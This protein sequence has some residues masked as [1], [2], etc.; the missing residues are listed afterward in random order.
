ME[1]I[2]NQPIYSPTYKQPPYTLE[3]ASVAM[4]IRQINARGKNIEFEVVSPDE[5]WRGKTYGEWLAECW[6]KC[7]S[8]N[9]DDTSGGMLFLRASTAKGPLVMTG[10]NVATIS[11]DTSIFLP[12]ITAEMDQYDSPDLKTEA[13]WRAAANKDIDEGDP[14]SKIVATIDDEA[15]VNDLGGFRV[16]SPVFSLNVPNDSLLKDDLEVKEPVGTYEAVA[17]GYCLIIKSLPS[18]KEPYTIKIKAKGRGAY[19]Q[20]ETYDIKVME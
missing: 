15:I 11:S 1:S 4:V 3:C 6:Q 12:V 17:A 16:E 19:E 13:A 14:P 9:P 7:L 2:E 10:N 18:R 20:D 5:S 8:S